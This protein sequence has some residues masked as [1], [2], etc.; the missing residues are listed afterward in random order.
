MSRYEHVESALR[1]AREAGGLNMLH[2]P[3]LRPK[4]IREPRAE[5]FEKHLNAVVHTGPIHSTVAGRTDHLPMGVPSGSYVLSADVVSHLGE[6]NTAAGF[7][8][9]KRMFGG[10]PRGGGSQPY[11]HE[12]GPYGMADGGT[13][14]QVPIVAAGGEYVVHP[15]HVKQ[16]GG[17]DLDT[18]HK[19]LDEFSK[20]IRAEMV[21]TLK[22]LP[23]PKKD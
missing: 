17:G 14:K 11:N 6:N 21:K 5:K 16:I 13:A 7:A 8:N 23:G 1:V 15:H 9:L 20:R 3:H 18:G 22:N 19:V 4:K 2:V 10:T 12:G